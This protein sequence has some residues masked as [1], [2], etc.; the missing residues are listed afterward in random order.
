MKPFRVLATLVA[1]ASS[2]QTYEFNRVE[3][4]T[5]SQRRQVEVFA[6]KRLKP[7]IML[8]VDNSGSMLLPTDT[9]NSACPAGCGSSLQNRCP[10]ACPTRVTEMRAAMNSFL[11]NRGNVARFG[12][13][14]FPQVD[15]GNACRAPV[16]VNE[17]IPGPT[18]NDEGTDQA[19]IDN[20]RKVNDTLRTLTNDPTGGTPTGGAL[21]F[22]STNPGLNDLNDGRTDLVVLLTDGLPNC[23]TQA[24]ASLCACAQ[25][26][27][28]CSTQQINACSCT[29]GNC[30]TTTANYC[31]IGCLDSDNSVAQVRALFQKDIR[32]V[33]VGFGADVASGPGPAVLK[34]M[35]DEGGFPRRCPDGTTGECGGGACNTTTHLCEQSF[36]A[37]SNATELEDALAKISAAV[38]PEP[39]KFELAEKPDEPGY[40]S[41]LIDGENVSPSPTTWEYV[42]AQQAVIFTGDI[43]ERLRT[44]TPQEPVNLEF[45]IVKRL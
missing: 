31:N 44:S 6:S 11:T 24:P 5:V 26:G 15:T 7:N 36:Y 17:S 27:Q 3:P 33:V 28:S 38:D 16:V 12:L 10:A 19:L 40:L 8:L 30:A 9:T 4:F 37:A 1:L 23:N 22:V 39:C 32:T 20:A 29:L 35:A 25:P 45:R 13:T 14:V 21:N 43:C 42:E 34:A 2:C 18:R 41:V